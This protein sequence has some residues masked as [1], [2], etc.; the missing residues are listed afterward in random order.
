MSKIE[1]PPDEVTDNALP[2]ITPGNRMQPPLSVR[3]D[4]GK[5]RLWLEWRER[6]ERDWD[7]YQQEE[8]RSQW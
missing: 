5:L 4:P 7:Y 1:A 3:R 6:F 8:A 2:P